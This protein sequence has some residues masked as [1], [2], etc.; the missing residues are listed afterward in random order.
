MCYIYYVAATCQFFFFHYANA[1]AFFSLC[2]R[3]NSTTDLL[4]S[5]TESSSLTEHAVCRYLIYN[6]EKSPGGDFWQEE[7]NIQ[8][9]L[10]IFGGFLKVIKV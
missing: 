10:L 8:N 6:S 4:C 1:A 5:S 3:A 9:I 7:V 2:G